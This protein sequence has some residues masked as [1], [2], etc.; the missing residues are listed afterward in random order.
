MRHEVVKTTVERGGGFIEQSF[1]INADAKMFNLLSDKIYSDKPGALVRELPSNAKDAHI[2]FGI[3]DVPFDIHL[4]NAL[5]PYFSVRDYGK[6]LTFQEMFDVYSRYSESTKTDNNQEIGKFGLGAKSPFAYTDSFTVVSRVGG[7]KN[8]YTAYIGETGIPV[9]ALLKNADGEP[10]HEPCDEP[11]GLEVIVPIKAK[12]YTVFQKKVFHS[13]QYFDPLPNVKGLSSTDIA[14]DEHHYI[15]KGSNW[16]IRTS[17]MSYLEPR[18]IQGGVFYPI[19]V[20]AVYEERPIP[21][22]ALSISK[23]PIDI[24]FDMFESDSERGCL[25]VALSR[26]AL[27]YDSYTRTKL[28][29]IINQV[30]SELITMMQTRID[31]ADTYWNACIIYKDML[32]ELNDIVPNTLKWK[33]LVVA[34]FV[35]M[36]LNEELRNRVVVKLFTNM[37][38]WRNG[39]TVTDIAVRPGEAAVYMADVSRGAIARCAYYLK[40]QRKVRTVILVKPINKSVEASNACDTILELLGRPSIT[41]VSELPKPPT[42]VDVPTDTTRP[43]C[44]ALNHQEHSRVPSWRPI[45]ATNMPEQ[46]YYLQMYKNGFMVDD[47]MVVGETNDLISRA[48]QLKLIP[49]DAEIYGFKKNSKRIPPDTTKWVDLVEFLKTECSKPEYQSVLI[50]SVN[51]QTI[52][53]SL[54]KK[55]TSFEYAIRYINYNNL[56]QY[57]PLITDPDVAALFTKLMSINGTDST[58]DGAKLYS[59]CS[60]LMMPLPSVDDTSNKQT[61][62]ELLVLFDT[63]LTRYKILKFI[64][65]YWFDTKERASALIQLYNK[66]TTT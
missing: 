65:G 10:F 66:G 51:R 13:L 63:M 37:S 36:E 29:D 2:A 50:N 3:P 1:S 64:N 52:H 46:G 33:G 44:Y 20:N 48:K 47:V 59:L 43:V 34:N 53:A 42:L 60:S 31:A 18:L 40:S 27:S 61:V 26:E 32:S 17:G 55:S 9:L 49:T 11:S 56:K 28:K 4:P 24:Y 16:G 45:K 30:Y 23:Q 38:G 21:G 5:Y 62:D 54:Y 41:A 57:T 25:D 15:F 6:G 58:V 19:D 12:D 8:T 22:F 14:F 39:K 35:R 7:I